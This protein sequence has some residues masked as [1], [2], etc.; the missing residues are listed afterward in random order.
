MRSQTF[1]STPFARALLS[2]ACAW[3]RRHVGSARPVFDRWVDGLHP[4]FRAEM[5]ASVSADGVRL[6]QAAK[7]VISSQVFAFNLFAPFRDGNSGSIARRL[8]LRLGV[9]VDIEDVSFEWIPPGDLL[10]EVDGDRPRPDEPAT[11][12]DVMLRGRLPDLAPAAILLEVK[13]SEGGFTCCG[14]RDSPANRRTDVCASAATFFADPTACHLQRPWGKS[15]DRRYWSIYEA[16]HGS[17]RAAF[18]GAD[19]NGPCPFADHAQQPMRNL[20]IARGLEQSGRVAR[21]WFGLCAHDDN[22]D[23]AAHWGAWRALLPEPSMAPVLPASEVLAAG[24]DAGFDDWA[25]W[26]SERYRLRSPE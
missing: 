4:Q 15:R 13:L 20:A 24:R 6:H 1:T 22:P 19:V 10:G 8:A 5:E 7:T 3:K 21:T 25:A 9:E 14:G 2:H 17:V 26:M 18:P 23:V 16:A 11:G 12:V